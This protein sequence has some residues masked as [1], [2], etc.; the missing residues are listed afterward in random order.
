MQLL[1]PSNSAR[2]EANQP[3]NE[4]VSELSPETEYDDNYL[5]NPLPEN[6]HV[7]V[8]EERLYNDNEKAADHVDDNETEYVPT[9]I[10]NLIL[11]LRI[12]HLR[13]MKMIWQ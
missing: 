4:D 13:R 9:V 1:D 7:G 5:L 11:T 8:D 12:H 6:E 10:L 3:A 2:N